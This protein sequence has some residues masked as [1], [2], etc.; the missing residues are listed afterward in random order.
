MTCDSLEFRSNVSIT[1]SPSLGRMS[2]SN[3]SRESSFI[4]SVATLLLFDKLDN[5]INE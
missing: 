1:C 2:S 3:A 5:L 4:S